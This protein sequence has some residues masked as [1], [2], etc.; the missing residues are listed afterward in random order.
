MLERVVI[1]N[2]LTPPHRPPTQPATQSLTRAP[3]N[4][5]CQ[6]PLCHT[7][8]TLPFL[9]ASSSFSPCCRVCLSVCVLLQLCQL[10]NRDAIADMRTLL[11]SSTPAVDINSRDMLGRTALHIAVLAGHPGAVRFLIDAGA[12]ITSRLTDGRTP[13]HIAASELAIAVTVTVTV[14]V[15]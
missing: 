8:H 12:R 11:S 9:Y 3:T 5:L 7:P 15:A 1:S 10:A 14:I 13:L 6:S 4:A 2:P